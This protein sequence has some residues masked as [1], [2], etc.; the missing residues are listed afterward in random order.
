MVNKMMFCN[1]HDTRT[2]ACVCVVVYV[3]LLRTFLPLFTAGRRR[4]SN[5]PMLTPTL[6]T[7]FFG[8]MRILHVY[9]LLPAC[10]CW[11]CLDLDSG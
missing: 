11:S 1:R 2:C 9:F 8:L 6:I 3:C 7:A 4:A 10:H 5:A